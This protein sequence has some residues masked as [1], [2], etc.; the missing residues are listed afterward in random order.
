VQRLLGEW[1]WRAAIVCALGWIGWELH[2][3][4]VNLKQPDDEATVA[5]APDDLQ[6]R[7]D[8]LID[9]VATLNAKIDAIMVAML[10]LKR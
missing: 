6:D 10:Q 9:D 4:R 5:A 8:A 2:Q 7:L 3:M 1:L